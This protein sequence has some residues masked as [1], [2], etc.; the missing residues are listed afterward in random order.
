[1]V[2]THRPFR[3]VP[4]FSCRGPGALGLGRGA[5]A[6]SSPLVWACAPQS[7]R[8]CWS[9]LRRAPRQGCLWPGTD[10]APGGGRIPERPGGDW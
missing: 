7:Q 10:G 1:M 5:G 9:D 3:G 2:N 6:W 8:Q 4:G